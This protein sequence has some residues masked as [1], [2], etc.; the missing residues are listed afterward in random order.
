MNTGTGRIIELLFENGQRLARIA[1]SQNLIPSAGQ[2]LQAGDASNEP[3]PVSLF[4]T[5]STP[6]GFI[7]APPLRES[8]N[9]G[10]E[11]FLRGP[12]GR[13]FAVPTSARKIALIAYDE[14]PW[15]LQGL[16]QPAL[17]RGAAVV[18]VCD[19]SFDSLPDDVEIQ[20][21]STLNEIMAWADY[22]AFDVVREKLF[23]LNEKLV[24][25]KKTPVHGGAEILI[26]TSMPCSGIAECD[27][28]AV[29][30]K[31]GWGMVCKDGPVF[32]AEEI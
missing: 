31:S 25:L 23:E 9:V 7:T 18:M 16:I 1:C 5:D 13:G 4:Y 12:L 32:R 24:A 29:Q 2:Y 3:L 28:C 30:V 10:Q 11:L 20:P 27:V 22:A 14:L 21:L 6:D 17:K 8:W 19:K 15:R 26:R